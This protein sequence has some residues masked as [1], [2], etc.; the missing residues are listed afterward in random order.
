VAT[1][2]HRAVDDNRPRPGLEEHY[3]RF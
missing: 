3:G 2:A 1:E